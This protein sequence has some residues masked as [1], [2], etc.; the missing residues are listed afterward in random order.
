MNRAFFSLC[1]GV[2]ACV[3]ALQ[4]SSMAIAKGPETV[5]YRFGGDPDGKAP[6][7][8][9]DVNGT[10]YGTTSFGGTSAG[11]FHGCGTVFEVDE[12]TGAESVVYSFCGESKK[13]LCDDGQV[14]GGLIKLKGKLYGETELGGAHQGG[15]VFA[16][17]PRTRRETIL[18][19]FCTQ[20][21]CTD[22]NEPNAG[23]IAVNGTLY[24][25]TSFGGAYDH[26]MVF[27]LDPSTGAE[28]VL[29]SF[30]SGG[31]PCTD[32]DLPNGGLIAARGTLYGT[33]GRGGANCQSSLGCGTLFALDP[34]TGVETVLYSFCSQQNCTDGNEPSADMIDVGGTL[35]GTTVTGGAYHDAGTVFAFNPDT[36][37]ETVVYS[38]CQILKTVC[39]DGAG[40]G[41]GLMELKGRLYGTTGAGGNAIVVCQSGCGTVFDLNPATGAERVLY[42]FCSQKICKDG[43]I[44]RGLFNVTGTFYGTTAEG[45]RYSHHCYEGC[46]TVFTLRH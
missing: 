10:L 27:A 45:G 19:S 42:S 35:Y 43:E 8:L 11:C 23:L 41:G 20:Q 15:T 2:T 29:Y 24:G 22:G 13:K 36:G 30:C 32:G 5:L 12:A 17:D 37:S 21:S 31:H 18:Y 9:I 39:K 3:L 4:F 26:G 16:F 40:P 7:S 44:P 33:T 14:P 1:A 46:G 25:T 34:T 6:S 28:T 38:F